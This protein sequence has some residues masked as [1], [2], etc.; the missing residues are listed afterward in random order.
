MGH[1][2]R[3]LGQMGKRRVEVQCWIDVAGLA[4]HPLH[5][6]FVRKREHSKIDN[7]RVHIEGMIGKARD[8]QSVTLC[9]DD[10]EPFSAPEALGLTVSQ[11]M[12]SMPHQERYRLTHSPV[13]RRLEGAK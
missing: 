10:I 9:Q 4:L 13:Q 6:E 8:R 12:E 7:E 11:H 1:G 2:E 3:L 5:F